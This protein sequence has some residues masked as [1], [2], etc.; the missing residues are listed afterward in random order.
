MVNYF[1]FIF[2]HLGFAEPKVLESNYP[3]T[4]LFEDRQIV[5]VAIDNA[6]IASGDDA[7]VASYCEIYSTKGWL[8]HVCLAFFHFFPKPFT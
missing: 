3:V 5:A 7:I 6:L 1:H 8:T 2:V 4:H